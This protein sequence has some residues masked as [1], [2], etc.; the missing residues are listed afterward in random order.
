[1]ATDPSYV[2]HA[3][4]PG[5][6]PEVVA[7][8]LDAPEHM[9]AE[10]VDGELFVTPR[11]RPRHAHASSRL[12]RRLGPFSDPIGDEPG[13]WLILD[14]PEL[15]L[16]PR[17]DIIDPDLA[18]WCRERMPRLPDEAAITT[19]P[20][21]VCEVLSDRTEALDRGRKIRVFR[22]EGVGHVWLVS[23]ELRTVEVYRLENGRYSLLDTFEGEQFV[24]AE[25]FELVELALGALWSL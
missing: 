8:Y 24:R 6:R 7:G 11:P 22:R 1:M 25:P 17:P 16:G 5:L 2:A 9:V 12:G 15:H 14:E 21:W 3:S 18:G 19:P 20:D 10:V 4:F 13:G 23:P